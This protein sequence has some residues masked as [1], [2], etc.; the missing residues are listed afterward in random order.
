[1]N[2]TFGLQSGTVWRRR[3]VLSALPQAPAGGNGMGIRI[4]DRLIARSIVEPSIRGQCLNGGRPALLR[5]L[6]AT[7]S[8]MMAMCEITSDSWED[9]VRKAYASLRALGEIAEPSALPSVMDGLVR[10]SADKPRVA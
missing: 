4:L 7:Q 1:M 8:V 9:F 6:G 5:E 3:V 2:A 10:V